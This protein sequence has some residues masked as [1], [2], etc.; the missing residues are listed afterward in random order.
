MSDWTEDERRMI[1]SG[2]RGM[3]AYAIVIGLH[4]VAIFIALVLYEI[5]LAGAAIGWW[6]Q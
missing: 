2:R 3:R 1:R 5:G 4:A 6:L